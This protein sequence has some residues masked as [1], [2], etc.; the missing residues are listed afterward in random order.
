MPRSKFVY[1]REWITATPL[2]LK[3]CGTLL[4]SC[5]DCKRL[6]LSPHWYSIV[7]KVFRCKR[8][9]TPVGAER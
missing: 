4:P 7:R 1:N 8:C 6:S 3:L 2:R 9:F 5:E